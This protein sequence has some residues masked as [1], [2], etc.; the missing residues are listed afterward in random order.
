MTEIDEHPSPSAE[1]TG[2]PVVA[3]VVDANVTTISPEAA[4]ALR[5]HVAEA[6]AGGN[7]FV[8][9]LLGFAAALVAGAVASVAFLAISDRD[10]DGNVDVNVPAVE[11]DVDG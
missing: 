4:E 6:S 2:I 10:D 11:V 7:R 8:W 9:F 3:G 1:R 5:R